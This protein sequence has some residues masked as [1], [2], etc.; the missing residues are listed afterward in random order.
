MFNLN[1]E[2]FSHHNFIRSPEDSYQELVRQQIHTPWNLTALC[3]STSG[4]YVSDQQNLQEVN[5]MLQTA[6]SATYPHSHYTHRIANCIALIFTLQVLPDIPRILLYCSAFIYKTLKDIISK[7][8]A[9]SISL[10]TNTYIIKEKH[11]P[12]ALRH[13][14]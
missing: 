7:S 5:L 8:T 3:R 1:R 4:N 10:S 12:I 11:L 6:E 13:C 9:K 2:K 14:P